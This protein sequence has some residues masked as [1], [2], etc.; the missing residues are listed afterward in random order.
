MKYTDR[1]GAVMCSVPQTEEEFLAGLTQEFPDDS[2]DRDD[3]EDESE[4]S[5]EEEDE[6]Y[7][8][9]ESQNGVRSSHS[10]E[11][12]ADIVTMVTALQQEGMSGP[13]LWLQNCLNRTAND[14]EED[15]FSQPVA[16]VPLTEA[17]EEAMDNKSFQRLL[18]KLGV[19]APADEQE[20]FWRIPAKLSVSQLRSAAAAL[21]PTEEEAKGGEAEEGPRSPPG[22]PQE[23]EQE[24]EEDSGEQR[25][26]ALR[27]LLLARK[28]KQHHAPEQ[29]APVSDS[30]PS[31]K[32]QSPAER[33]QSHKTSAK[34]SRSR[35]LEDD[36]EEEEKND[37]DAAAVMDVD[38]DADSDGEKNTSAPVK[39]RRKMVLIDEEDDE[40]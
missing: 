3:E 27:A 15:G 19:R 7:E 24:E 32:T 1:C 17:N 16:L 2:V 13:L 37:G 5:E 6:G 36:D 23:E 34:R 30:A 8:R 21:S 20:S 39:R 12:R 26:Q 4:E 35:V 22:E 38:G 40:D 14:R 28:R 9:E 29:T 25:A 33:S 10:V 18:R 11:R 31:E